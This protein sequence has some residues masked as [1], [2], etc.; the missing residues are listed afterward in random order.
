MRDHALFLLLGLGA[1]AVY[2]SLGLGL[3]MVYRVSRVVNVAQ[4][5]MASVSAYLFLDLRD[6]LAFGPALALALVAAAAL[7]LVVYAAVFRPLHRAPA[8]SRVVASVGVMITLQ[9]AIV[10]RFGSSN[11][12]VAPILPAEPISL[13]GV[14]VPR[15]RLILA[16]LA[17]AAGAVLWALGRFTRVGLATRAVA[18]DPD[19][20]A[21]L[22]WSPT[23][24]A[25]LTWAVAGVLAG[26]AGILA[27]PISSLNPTTYSLLVV[28]ALGAALVGGLSSFGGTVAAGLALG[29]AQSVVV[30]VQSE[31]SWLSIPGLRDGLAFLVIV[32]AITWRGRTLAAR[33][34][35][36]GNDLPLATRPGLNRRTLAVTG[37]GCAVVAAALFGLGSVLRLALIHSLI[38]AVVC[39]SLVLLTGYVGQISLAQMTFAGVAGFILTRLGTGIPF[40][41]APLLAAT[42]AALLGLLVGIPA[43]RV[44]GVNLAV[45]TLAGAV[46]VEEL[47][48]K[49]PVLV[50]GIAGRRVPEPRL[51]G[52]DLGIGGPGATTYPRPVFGLFVLAI[53]A[54]LCLG[55]VWLRSAPLGRRF[56]AVRSNE[57]AAA[58]VGIGVEEAKLM[59]FA[60]SA[61][62]AGLGGV[63]LGYSQGRL[64]YVSFGVFASLAYLAVT[65]VGGIARVSGALV[66]GAL[67]SGGIVFAALDQAADLGRYELLVTGV[68]LVVMAVLYPDGVASAPARVLRRLRARA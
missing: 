64:T 16:G 46:A 19:A 30:K 59:G 18:D 4:G 13:F 66:G 32:V 1:G 51:F 48:F 47:V 7:G 26:L 21:L 25:A 14:G 35:A 55:V 9:A 67:A 39:L 58:S 24:M 23:R 15:D 8:L 2:A 65:Y 11:R 52:I 34:E 27:A 49:N 3:V 57:R 68:A 43:L 33:G 63:L 56:L 17:V 45:V 38:G 12:S 44:R 54:A 40:P 10:L 53:L 37:V 62:V 42:V 31:V 50:G 28:P 36:T 60:L 61:F 20:A 6:D 41:L 5:A 29:M 22:G